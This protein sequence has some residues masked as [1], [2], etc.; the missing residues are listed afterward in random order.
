MRVLM[1][2]AEEG[3]GALVFTKV[4]R[5]EA[6]GDCDSSGARDP[7][8]RALM[9][10]HQQPAA[11]PLCSRTGQLAAEPLCSR[12]GQLAAGDFA[13]QIFAREAERQR[14]AERERRKRKLA[15]EED[16]R[17]ELKLAAEEELLATR[18]LPV[19][20]TLVPEAD[21]ERQIDD[22]AEGPFYVGA[23]QS[24][25]RRWEGA[26]VTDR[27]PMV[28]HGR[29]WGCMH[30]IHVASGPRGATIEADLI[31]YVLRR[32]P[33]WCC[34]KARDARGLS[35]QARANFIYVVTAP[36]QQQQ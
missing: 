15:A 25:K 28:G 2:V 34:N 1:D 17:H 11:E 9:D 35:I 10:G 16:A 14:E 26:F 8:L 5:C 21:L 7:W 3:A 23:T 12:T 13:R 19:Y 20:W 22:L 32:Y 33:E 30:V 18:G 31:K 36:R 27:G 29:S 6:P 4:R 24:P